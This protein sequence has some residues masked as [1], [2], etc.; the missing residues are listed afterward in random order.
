MDVLLVGAAVLLVIG[1]LFAFLRGIFEDRA[2]THQAHQG[3]LRRMPDE[4]AAGRLVMSEERVRTTIGDV[5]VYGRT[6]QV[7]QT[8]D[9][10]LVPVENKT[11]QYS[12]VYGS[13]LI[14]V[15]LEAQALRAGRRRV[16][17]HGYIRTRN[18]RTSEVLYHRVA[19]MPERILRP[20]VD[21]YFDIIE[22]RRSPEQQSNPR[23]CSR[24]QFKD[25]CRPNGT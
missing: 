1:G 8:P 11:R 16:A 13:D 7:Y 17:E 25:R 22:G 6:E 19:L 20:L 2:G 21:R 12:K 14:Q 24:C 9:G 18:N 3:E 23:A 10:V 15:S 5:V 4:I